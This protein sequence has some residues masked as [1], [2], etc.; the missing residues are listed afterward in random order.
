VPL[1]HIMTVPHPADRVAELICSE[2][3][4]LEVQRAR[5]DMVEAQ[6]ARIGEDD[7]EIRYEIACTTY[8]R[9]LKGAIDRSGT[10]QSKLVYRYERQG[11]VL[12]WR[13]E[14]EASQ[15]SEVHG[16]THFISQGDGTRVER[17]V[18][19]KI[20]IPVVGKAIAKLVERALRKGFDEVEDR[21]RRMLA[22]G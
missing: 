6:Y 8:K 16:V 9:S 4:N 10:E 22:E 19:V 14:G 17:E 11:R 12:H 2:R 13:H 20:R 3:Y 21:I 1:S 18:T 7:A 5:E 15:R